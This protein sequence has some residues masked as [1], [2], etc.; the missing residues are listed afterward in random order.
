MY[1][2]DWASQVIK[3]PSD[4]KSTAN[5]TDTRDTGLIHW[6]RTWQLTPVFLPGESPWK[7]EPEGLQSI[8]S[9]RLRHN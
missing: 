5:A 2:Q 4:K 3:N 8:G 7:E 6:R 1:N 9:Q